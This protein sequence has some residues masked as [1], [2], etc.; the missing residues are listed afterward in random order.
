MSNDKWPV[1]IMKQRPH[2]SDA[3]VQFWV[4]AIPLATSDFYQHQEIF[5]KK[6][7]SLRLF[8]KF[9]ENNKTR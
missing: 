2:S 4:G 8:L 6:K 9:M 1:E 3:P 7:I 5:D